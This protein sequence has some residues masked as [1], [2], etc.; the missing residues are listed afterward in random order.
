MTHAPT[1]S[2]EHRTMLLQESGIAPD[3]V[4]ERGYRTVTNPKDL[5]ALGFTPAQR[6]CPGLLLPLHPTGGG[7]PPL[8]V[9]RP[10]APRGRRDRKTGELRYVKYEVPAGHGTRIDYPPRCQPVLADPK[11]PLWITEGQ[12]KG[13]AL[14]SRGL[15][16][17]A[18]LGVWNWRGKNDLGGTTLLADLDYI[19]WDGRDVRLVFDS[20]VVTKPQVRAA[21]DRFTEHLQ[22]KGARVRAVY[23]PNGPDGAKVGVDDYLA[24]G[25]TVAD[26]EAL[27]EAPRP[28]PQAAPPHVELL[29]EAPPAMRR[30]LQIVGDHAYAAAWLPCRVTVRERLDKAGNILVVNPPEVTTETRLFVVRDDGVIFGEGASAPLE[31]LGFEVVLPEVPLAAKTWSTPGVKR[32]VSGHRPEPADVFRR[33]V[34]VVDRFE[35]FSHSLGEQRAMCELI[36][37]HIMH[38]YLLDAFQVTGH[39]WPNGDRGA[40]KTKLLLVHTQLAYLGQVILAGGSYASLRD[41]ADYGA[42]LAFDDAENLGN[43]KLT[44]PDKRALLLAGNR[45]GATVSLKEPKPD[46]TWRTRYVD[47]FCPRLFSAIRLPDPVLGSRTIVIPLVRTANREKANADPL[48]HEL[49]PHDR[50]QLLDDLWA[51]GLAHL[52]A[53]RQ[54][55]RQAARRARLSG[56]NLEPWRAILAVAL[57][58]EERGVD[59]LFGRMEALSVAYQEERPELETSDVT[60]LVLRALRECARDASDACDASDASSETPTFY[61]TSREVREAFDRF[62]EQSE[63]DIAWMGEAD[64][65]T[66][67]VGRLLGTLRFEKARTGDQRRWLIHGERL[68]QLLVSYGLV[69]LPSAPL[70]ASVTSVTCVTSV[71]SAPQGGDGRGLPDPAGQEV[72]DPPEEPPSPL[73]ERILEALAEM[74]E[75]GWP[76]LG[77]RLRTDGGLVRRECERLVREGRIRRAPAGRYAP[78]GR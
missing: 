55:D 50:R 29:D 68:E 23:L 25:H 77:L 24:Q 33:I 28:A 38:S 36:A 12:K 70:G 21:L 37:C 27:V 7:K 45:K 53:M 32:Y 46:G 44:D 69:T 3:V 16:A 56:R 35:D 6:R 39:L 58:L 54:Y 66:M 64:K 14:A 60:V 2:P 40:G 18:L 57:W 19:A 62:A 71:M 48:D 42:V 30:P 20:D 31:A 52:V 76:R 43:P 47:A 51:L 1:L 74:G 15:C 59:G 13:D 26:L 78:V 22:R 4:A 75:A 11:V 61:T 73:G 63:V 72:A 5:E 41:L 67:R 17:V 8:H 10:N 34:A 49:W 65:R 9:Y